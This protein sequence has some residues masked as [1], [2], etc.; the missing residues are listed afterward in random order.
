MI[1]DFFNQVK[2]LLSGP[3]SIGRHRCV[4]HLYR[5]SMWNFYR[6]YK[7]RLRTSFGL[8][9]KRYS[10]CANFAVFSSPVISP[11]LLIC[12]CTFA[13]HSAQPCANRYSFT[14]CITFITAS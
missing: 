4:T 13:I 5:I 3:G 6:S 2:L 12:T 8:A 7:L 14:S 1:K 11:L 10:P 9:T